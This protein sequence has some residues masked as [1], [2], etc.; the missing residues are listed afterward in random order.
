MIRVNEHYRY[1]NEFLDLVFDIKANV[2]SKPTLS[3]SMA[4]KS[5]SKRSLAAFANDGPL[6]QFPVQLHLD[7]IILDRNGKYL[8]PIPPREVEWKWKKNSES[9]GSTGG[10][11]TVEAH[12]YK[13]PTITTNHGFIEVNRKH[14]IVAHHLWKRPEARNLWSAARTTWSRPW[15]VRIHGGE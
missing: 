7:P 9:S 4:E 3:K 14:S 2:L 13:V 11:W 15:M 6:F 10:G 1:L 12:Y 8:Q 5:N